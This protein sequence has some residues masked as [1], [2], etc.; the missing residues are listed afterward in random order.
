MNKVVIHALQ[1]I[2]LYLL[3]YYSKNNKLLIIDKVFVNSCL[4]MVCCENV[5]GNDRPPSEKI[6]KQ[7]DELKKFYNK[8]Y[9]KLTADK[10]DYQHLNT[11]LDYLIIDIITMYENN[12]KL[13][14]VEYL[15]RYV[16][17]VWKKKLM[18]DKI[19]K[20]KKNE[21]KEMKE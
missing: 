9:K 11:V 7:R 17:V 16:N 21:K 14:Y 1:F 19:R 5:A 10:L 20:L 2:K 4:K 13:H 3:D 6:K 15:E 12:I 18:T 8:N